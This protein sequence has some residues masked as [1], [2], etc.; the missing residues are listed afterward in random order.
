MLRTKSALKALRQ[1]V[2][3]KKH[4]LQRKAGLKKAIKT[5]QKAIK[6]RELEEAKK[7][8]SE[9]YKLADKTAKTKTIKKGKADRIK[10]RLAQLLVKKSS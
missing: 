5:Y 7:Y 8:L 4:N 1:S 10:S 9:V 2:R 6:S 3:R